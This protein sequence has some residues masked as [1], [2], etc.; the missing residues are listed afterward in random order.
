MSGNQSWSRGSF[1][2]WRGVVGTR[3]HCLPHKSTGQWETLLSAHTQSSYSLDI[4]G[5]V[6]RWYKRLPIQSW[7]GPTI[8]QSSCWPQCLV[9]LPLL[10]LTKQPLIFHCGASNPDPDYDN[11][12]PAS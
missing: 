1:L 7:W 6:A 10:L 11:K 12:E 2:S 4:S 5:V 9:L 8:V 3:E